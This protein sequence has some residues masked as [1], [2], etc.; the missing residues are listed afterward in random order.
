MSLKDAFYIHSTSDRSDLMIKSYPIK[1]V[2][3]FVRL[4]VVVISF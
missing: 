3:P 4:L 1:I 2:M